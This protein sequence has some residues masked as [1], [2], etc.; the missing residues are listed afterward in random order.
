MLVR[1]PREL[2]ETVRAHAERSGVSM[3]EYIVRILQQA[4]R[5]ETIVPKYTDHTEDFILPTPDQ[6]KDMTDDEV[7]LLAERMQLVPGVA[8][9]RDMLTNRDQGQEH[10][11][12][13]G[14]VDSPFRTVSDAAMGEIKLEIMKDLVLYDTQFQMNPYQW[15]KNMSERLLAEPA[16]IHFFQGPGGRGMQFSNVE[17]A[18][19]LS[20]PKR[21]IVHQVTIQIDRLLDPAAMKQLSVEFRVGEKSYLTIPIMNMTEQKPGLRYSHAVPDV[22][23]PPVQNFVVKL[24]TGDKWLG[25]TELR[26]ELLTDL[27][28]EIQ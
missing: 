6:I 8:H 27:Y 11:P 19:S 26:C 15:P 23:I 14:H 18:G 5:M 1:V 7:R 28:R 12:L 9:I 10:K 16:P 2:R 17:T 3:N 4:D 25:E 13:G 20:W 21:A 24:M 22:L